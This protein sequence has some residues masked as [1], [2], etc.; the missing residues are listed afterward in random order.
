MPKPLTRLAFLFAAAWATTAC[1]SDS[2]RGL[3]ASLLPGQP[4]GP[5]IVFE[6]LALPNPRVPFPNDL[7]LRVRANGSLGVNVSMQSPTRIE[8]R[9]RRHL[10]EIDGFSGLTPITVQFDGPLDLTT[11]TDKTLYVINVS[12]GSKRFGERCQLDLGRGWFPHQADPHPYLPHDP[13]KD[14][15]SYV[16]PPDNKVD[17][18]GDGKP[19][20][21]VYHYEVATNT[22]DIRPLLPLEAGAQ[23]AVVLTRG[24][25]GWTQDGKYGPVRSPFDVVNHDS[26]TPALKRALPSLAEAGVQVADVA[27]AWTLTTG[28]LARTFR[29]LRDGLYGKGPF[30]WLDK[31]FPAGIGDVYD[32]QI[33]F[34]GNASHPD[35][36]YPV[37]QWDHTY[38]LQG[39]YLKEIFGLINLVQ[40]GVAGGFDYASHAVFGDMVT[41]N[42]RATPDNVWQLDLLAGTVGDGKTFAKKAV[43]ERVPFMLV[44]PKTTAHHKPPF[45]VTVYAHATGTSRVE[46]LLMADRLAQAGIATFAIDAVGHGPVLSEPR[47]MIESG[48]AKFGGGDVTEVVRDLLGPLLYLDPQ[49]ELPV[50][51]T[52]QQMIDKLLTHGFMQQLAVKGRATDDNGDCYK[53]GGEAYFAPD[54]FRLRDSMRQTTLDF[55]VGV[56]A[57][58][59]LGKVPPPPKNP[60]T[61]TKA[62]LM[63]SLLAGDFDLDGVLD[64][65]GALAQDGKA[66]PYFMMGVSLG[67]IHTA[68]TAPLEPFIVASAPVVP[69]AGLADIFMRT[70]LHSVVTPLM[71]TISGP[72]LVGCPQADGKVALS[73]NNDSDYCSK[74]DKTYYDDAKT[75]K[76]LETAEKR[77]FSLATLA[78][79]EGARV[80]LRNLGPNGLVTS[81]EVEGQAG[82]QGKFALAVAADQGDLM[83]IEVFDGN[84]SLAKQAFKTPHEGLGR[85]RNTPEFRRFVQL[86]ANVLEGADAITVADRVMR[87]PLPGHAPTSMLMLLAVGDQTVPFNSGISLARAIGLFGKGDPQAADAPYRS[88]TEEAIQSGLLVGEDVPPPILNPTFPEAGPGLCRLLPTHGCDAADAKCPPARSGVCMAD[89][90]GHHEYIAQVK[91]NTNTFPAV[92]GYAGSYTEYHKNVIV[93]YFHSLARRIGEDPCW[94]DIA[95]VKKRNL[96]AEWELPVGQVP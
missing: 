33:P 62:E 81:G 28:D 40:P 86:A 45:P 17:T 54:A 72:M 44:I 31:Q 69:G 79:P 92:D 25:K 10:N 26:Q 8:A 35:K 39:A 59:A 84:K 87:D 49:K 93:T 56:R 22:L 83:E 55:L 63:P 32:M 42:L 70:R 38:V 73:W 9:Q 77:P 88:W 46:C 3:H 11:V 82:K 20:K 76:C 36:K 15:D 50:G 37:V 24:L 91:A 16:L 12:P 43:A 71:H 4:P 52:M 85:Q 66:Q 58:H 6:P 30:A 64:A 2:P 34:D 65:G 21:W 19:D 14:F 1:A 67:G 68:L 53:Q 75:G 7:A 60:A 74:Q 47:K 23:Y 89:V 80:V 51:M 48:L 5:E 41:P 90:H 57:L 61:A 13:Y 78:V 18:D 96:R 94:G 95:C 27:F 29:S